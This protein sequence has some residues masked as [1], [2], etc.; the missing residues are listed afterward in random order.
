MTK[1]DGLAANYD[2]VEDLLRSLLDPKET[3]S[4]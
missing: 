2:N 3:A 1:Y 4:G